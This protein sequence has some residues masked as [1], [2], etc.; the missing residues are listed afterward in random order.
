MVSYRHNP[1][2]APERY[3]I[4]GFYSRGQAMQPPR[5]VA[6]DEADAL[7]P[8]PL[9]VISKKAKEALTGGEVYRAVQ[10]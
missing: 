5:R 1:A 7:M 10:R 4:S 3:A 8:M 6:R 9:T 2:I